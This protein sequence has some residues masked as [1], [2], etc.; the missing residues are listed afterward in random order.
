VTR[1]CEDRTVVASLA[2]VGVLVLGSLIGFATGLKPFSAFDLRACLSVTL[3]G[4]SG[5]TGTS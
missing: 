2:F 5:A 3:Q 1:C 4:P